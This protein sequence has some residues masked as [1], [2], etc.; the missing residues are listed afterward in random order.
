MW[1]VDLAREQAPSR[2]HLATYCRVASDAGYDSLG[3]YLEHRFAYASAPWA[4]GTGAIT[5]DD[6]AWLRSEFPSLELVPFVNLLGH[7]EGFL[8]TEQGRVFREEGFRGMQA[9]ASNA[10]FRTLCTGLLD[11]TMR[12]FSSEMVHVGGDET[13]QLGKCGACASRVDSAEGD[14][15]AA[16][17]AEHFAPLLDKVAAA[18]RTPAVWGDMLLRHPAA[19]AALPR[20]AVVFDWQYF[21]GVRESSAAFGGRRVYGCPTFHVYN[22]A[23]CHLAESEA[24]IREVSHDVHDLGL[25][26]VCL[27]MW[28][29][30]LFG[31]F[32]PLFP[33]VGWTKSVIDDPVGAGSVFDAFSDQD[34]SRAW[35]TAMSQKLVEAGGVFGFSR[36]RSSLKCRLLL[37]GNPF[38]A[39][40][41]HHAELGGD[42]GSAMLAVLEKAMF[43]APG[44]AEKNATLFV[45]SAIEFVRL[46]EE[47][48][49]LYADGQPEA[50]ISKL[51]P[52][53]GLF[54][55]LENAARQ[56]HARIGG[57]LADVE[58]CRKAKLHIEEVLKRIRAYGHGELGYLPAF[59][60][61]THPKFVAH[62]QGCWWLI[63]RWGDE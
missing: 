44:E 41:H 42:A 45:R 11:D 33:A 55:V 53:R 26:G 40:R 19:E 9:C 8:Y 57:S 38:L 49:G 25:E 48:H 51:A 46:A 4:A 50:A 54:D 60:V 35:A 24:N 23:W 16:L 63:N 6:I 32:D 43:D 62:D 28:E 5:P 29:G 22:A 27:T 7:F 2:D 59:D 30:G 52:L 14:G 31:S 21:G 58:R 12:A 15:K 47:A 56:N 39:W 10:A 37:Y 3:L 20:E 34:G 36:M 61:I 13:D 1:M 18:G 17:Y